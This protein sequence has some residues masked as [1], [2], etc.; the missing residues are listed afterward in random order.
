M[1]PF[2]TLDLSKQDHDQLLVPD[3]DSLPPK[4]RQF[5]A[6]LVIVLQW[7]STLCVSPVGSS[8]E[9]ELPRNTG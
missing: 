8:S 5:A 9:L 1:S 7:R 3:R 4:V 2:L 6:S